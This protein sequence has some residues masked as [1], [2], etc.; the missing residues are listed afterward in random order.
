M[1]A[2]P[3]LNALNFQHL[4][5]FWTVASEGSIA[6]ATKVL[7][8][9]QPTISAQLKVLERSLGE[10]LF[11]RRGRRL[12]LTE[13]G[14]LVFRF[15]DDMFSIGRE[16]QKTL[17]GLPAPGR[18]TRFAVGVSDALPKLTTHRLLEPALARA[19]GHRLLLRIGKTGALLAELATHGLDVVLADAPAPAGTPGSYSHLLGESG[20]TVFAVP[21][22]AARHRRGFP[23]SLAGAPFLLQAPNSAL[24]RSLDAWFAATDVEPRVVAEV[25]DIAL[26]Q[27]FGGAGMGLFAAPTV[28]EADIR[29]AYGVRVVGRLPDVRE[30]F[31]AISMQRKLTHPAVVALRDAARRR[32]DAP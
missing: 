11:E 1:T 21:A 12:E 4:L 5:Y 10:R 26:L 25:E 32:L 31:Y 28:V 15:A 27:V 18:T 24:R 14:R 17:G 23:G 13:V 3:S 30:R 22:L 29:R 16:L 19:D 8:L 2:S 7:H 20:V 9:A 6:A